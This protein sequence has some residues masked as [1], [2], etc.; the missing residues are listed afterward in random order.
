[1]AL[2]YPDSRSGGLLCILAS[3]LLCLQPVFAAG[4]RRERIQWDAP[5]GLSVVAGVLT[6]QKPEVR[7]GSTV[8]RALKAT[9]IGLDGGADN[10]TWKFTG[11]VHLEFDGAV[12][13]A[14]AA[15]VVFVDNRL[16]SVEVQATASQPSPQQR[17][18]VHVELNGAQ[19]DAETAAVAFADG[20][21]KTVQ[22]QGA[23]A[24]FSHQLKKTGPRANGRANRINYDAVKTLMDLTEDTSFSYNG[25]EFETPWVKYNLTD[26]SYVTGPA[27]GKHDP[28]ERVPAPRTPDRTSAK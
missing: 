23:P 11:E 21:I 28:D 1:M 9:A 7:Q 24:L 4:E 26:S 17:K 3:A 19:L 13:D 15:T 16:S 8:L 25:N 2:M 22:A 5:G 12:L 27:N 6:L 18:P 10:S 14:Q 20:R